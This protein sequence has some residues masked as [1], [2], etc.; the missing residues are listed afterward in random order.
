[1]KI[2]APFCYNY[3][4]E[5]QEK[6][7][8]ISLIKVDRFFAWV[9]LISFF[10]YM[11]SGYGMTKGI[12]TWK[13]SRIFHRNILP[14][15]AT[16]SFIGHTSFAIRLT[17]M[18]NKIWNKF[19]KFLLITL[20]SITFIGFVYLELFVM[21]DNSI[22]K[23]NNTQEQQILVNETSNE[24]VVTND[25]D[26]LE[27]NNKKKVFTLEELSKYDGKNGNPAYT[28]VDGVVYDMT[29]VFENGIHFGHKAGEEL[30]KGF[31]QKHVKSTITK[32]PIVGILESN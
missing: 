1:M 12:S 28:A 32:Y 29:T 25:K 2:N 13:I 3:K 10:L 27:T 21:R 5:Q 31:Y 20:Y 14:V 18:R 8:K 11:F 4:M 9:L 15:I 19:T 7:P 16:L 22:T 6:K 17:L 30:T 24:N 23:N 26:R